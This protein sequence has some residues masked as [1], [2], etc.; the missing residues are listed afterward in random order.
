[1]SSGFSRFGQRPSG[2]NDD[3]KSENSQTPMKEGMVLDQS[4]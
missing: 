4:M 3:T 1:M 2:L